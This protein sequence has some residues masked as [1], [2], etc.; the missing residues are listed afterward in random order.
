MPLAGQYARD[1][2]GGNGYLGMMDHNA[3]GTSL[4]AYGN[5]SENQWGPGGDAANII[6]HLDGF[7]HFHG[8]ATKAAVNELFDKYLRSGSVL[9][10]GS[11]YCRLWSYA[12]DRHK[13]SWTSIDHNEPLL[14]EAGK[15]GWGGR[16]VA[17]SAD[18]MP[19]AGESFDNVVGL[20]AFNTFGRMDEA[21]AEA[22]RVLKPG[23]R[24]VHIQDIPPFGDHIDKEIKELLFNVL[25]ISISSLAVAE[26]ED[27]YGRQWAFDPP[28]NADA[29]IEAYYKGKTAL[30]AGRERKMLSEVIRQRNR[31]KSPDY[32]ILFRIRM[33]YALEETGFKI[34]ECSSAGYP[35]G[36]S[37]NAIHY[38]VAEKPASQD[39]VGAKTLEVDASGDS[40]PTLR[41]RLK[42]WAT[43]ATAE[44]AAK[45]L[46]DT[47]VKGGIEPHLVWNDSQIVKTALDK[48]FELTG[49][50]LDLA[51]LGINV[52]LNGFSK[53]PAFWVR[54]GQRAGQRL[55]VNIHARLTSGARPR[56]ILHELFAINDNFP[57]ILNLALANW[58]LPPSIKRRLYGRF[59]GRFAQPTDHAGGTRGGFFSAETALFGSGLV[60]AAAGMSGRIITTA[61]LLGLIA[62]AI[63]VICVA[64][65]LRGIQPEENAEKK[66]KR[67]PGLAMGTEFGISKR[68]FDKAALIAEQMEAAD[69][70]A[71]VA[72]G[73][74]EAKIQ[75]LLRDVGDRNA[76]EFLMDRVGQLR[77]LDKPDPEKP[78][79]ISMPEAALASAKPPVARPVDVKTGTDTQLPGTAALNKSKIISGLALVG[80]ALSSINA[81]SRFTIIMNMMGVALITTSIIAWVVINFK[82]HTTTVS[83]TA[84]RKKMK[85]LIGR[86]D[87]L[88]AVMDWVAAST[89]LRF[90][91]RRER[92]QPEIKFGAAARDLEDALKDESVK[93]V[94]LMGHGQWDAW[95][96]SDGVVDEFDVGRWSQK[97][98]HKKELFI[99]YACGHRPKGESR[100]AED[101]KLGYHAVRDPIRDVRGSATLVSSSWWYDKTS[102]F[103]L[104]ELLDMKSKSIR[105]MHSLPYFLTNIIAKLFIS[106]QVGTII[107]TT[108]DLLA[109][110]NDLYRCLLTGAI[111]SLVTVIAILPVVRY[112][113]STRHMRRIVDAAKMSGKGGFAARLNEPAEELPA[114]KPAF[115]FNEKQ[116]DASADK[117]AGTRDTKHPFQLPEIRSFDEL[118]EGQVVELTRSVK[119]AK[120]R[121]K[122]S[123]LF[124]HSVN[125][126]DKTVTLHSIRH[127]RKQERTIISHFEHP[128]NIL[129]DEFRVISQP[130]GRIA[131]KLRKIWGAHTI[132]DEALEII[133]Y[134]E[135]KEEKVRFVNGNL[136]GRPRQSMPVAEALAH[137]ACREWRVEKS[138]LVLMTGG[139][140]AGPDGDEEPEADNAPGK[141]LCDYDD[142]LITGTAK[143]L[144]A[145][146]ANDSERLLVLASW[147]K[148]NVSYSIGYGGYW[149]APA[150]LTLK[151]RNGMCFNQT[152]LLVAMARSLGIRSEYGVALKKKESFR[153]ILPPDRYAKVGDYSEHVFCRFL[154]D[155][156]WKTADITYCHSAWPP[157]SDKPAATPDTG[158]I[159]YHGSLDSLARGKARKDTAAQR[160]DYEDRMAVSHIIE[161]LREDAHSRPAPKKYYTPDDETGP[162]GYPM[163]PA[164][165]AK[166]A[167]NIAAIADKETQD[168]YDAFCQAS[169]ETARVLY[170]YLKGWQ[171]GSDD[172]FVRERLLR[173]RRLD[174]SVPGVIVSLERLSE[175][176]AG[177]IS[178]K[179]EAAEPCFR[180]LSWLTPDKQAELLAWNRK[181][182]PVPGTA[183]A[184]R[185]GKRRADIAMRTS[186]SSGAIQEMDTPQ[187]MPFVGQAQG[188]LKIHRTIPR[189]R[190]Q[191]TASFPLWS[192]IFRGSGMTDKDI[193][194][195]EAPALEETGIGIK[196]YID[197]LVASKIGW[198]GWI[199][200]IP[201]IAG[202]ILSS[203]ASS[204]AAAIIAAILFPQQVP[205][206]LP[207]II[208][209][210]SVIFA[211]MHGRQTFR[212]FFMRFTAGLVFNAA[213]LLIPAAY[214]AFMPFDHLFLSCMLITPTGLSSFLLAVAAHRAWNKIWYRL[215][216][217]EYVAAMDI[218]GPAVKAPAS[219][220][221]KLLIFAAV[222]AFSA[223]TASAQTDDVNEF[224]LRRA[225]D[226]DK[227]TEL[228]VIITQ[229]CVAVGAAA[230]IIL[231]GWA[232][233]KIMLM[234]RHIDRV[235][236]TRSGI[237]EFR[238]WRS[239][240]EAQARARIL[241]VGEKEWFG[242][243]EPRP[244]PYSTLK[245]Y[246]WAAI[247]T[248]TII[249]G[250]IVLGPYVIDFIRRARSILLVMPFLALAQSPTNK[251]APRD[252]ATF[253]SWV[254]GAM[255]HFK[256]LHGSLHDLIVL[257][258]GQRQEAHQKLIAQYHATLEYM[259]GSAR[260]MGL[261]E[262]EASSIWHQ[263][264]QD[265]KLHH[266]SKINDNGIFLPIVEDWEDM[267][268]NRNIQS[269][270][271]ALEAMVIELNEYLQFK[272]FVY[273]ESH[274]RGS[275][276]A[277]RYLPDFVESKKEGVSGEI[278][279]STGKIVHETRIQ[280]A[281]GAG[282]ANVLGLGGGLIAMAALAPKTGPFTEYMRPC[283]SCAGAWFIVLGV[284]VAVLA[285]SWVLASIIGRASDNAVKDRQLLRLEN[286]N[287][288]G[289]R[290]APV[291]DPDDVRQMIKHDGR[292]E[293]EGL[294][295]T[296]NYVP[297]AR[298]E[299]F[300]IEVENGERIL[301]FI[302]VNT[303]VITGFSDTEPGHSGEGIFVDT[304]YRKRGI[305]TALVSLALGIIRDRYDEC[306]V[307]NVSDDARGF[308]EASGF[309]VTE[310][311]FIEGVRVYRMRRDLARSELPEIK[312]RLTLSER[313]KKITDGLLRR[314][315]GAA[316]MRGKGGFAAR[317]NVT[318]VPGTASEGARHHLQESG[319][320]SQGAAD[321]PKAHSTA[322][323]EAGPA[324]P[325]IHMQDSFMGRYGDIQEIIEILPKLGI[326]AP[327]ISSGRNRVVDVGVGGVPFAACE[328]AYFLKSRNPQIEIVGTELPGDAAKAHIFMDGVTL[329]AFRNYIIDA[330]VCFRR[331]CPWKPS[332]ITSVRFV[333]NDRGKVTSALVGFG[334]FGVEV[335][336]LTLDVSPD[337]AYM[338][339]GNMSQPHEHGQVFA[340]LYK[341]VEDLVEP[342]LCSGKDTTIS[343]VKIVFDPTARRL[344]TVGAD[345]VV[346]DK[347]SDD[348]R[349][350]GAAIVIA[351]FTVQHMT[352]DQKKAF[353]EETV[354][355]MLQERG[356][357]IIKNRAAKDRQGEENASAIEV[358]QKRGDKIVLVGNAFSDHKERI[359]SPDGALAEISW[360]EKKEAS[361]YLIDMIR[362]AQSRSDSLSPQ[363][364]P[365]DDLIGVGSNAARDKSL[366]GS[367]GDSQGAA[368]V[369]L[370]AGPTS[371]TTRAEKGTVP[372]S[373]AMAEKVRGLLSEAD[374]AQ[375]FGNNHRAAWKVIDAFEVLRDHPDTRWS[376]DQ[377]RT[378]LEI[379]QKYEDRWDRQIFP[380]TLAL[381]PRISMKPFLDV[382]KRAADTGE[383]DDLPKAIAAVRPK[384]VEKHDEHEM[385]LI[386]R[387]LSLG[388]LRYTPAQIRELAQDDYRRALITAND[389]F[390]HV[391]LSA[392][393]APWLQPV[394]REFF[395]KG[396]ETTQSQRG[397]PGTSDPH[398]TWMYVEGLSTENREAL[399]RGGF[400]LREAAGEWPLIG[401]RIQD[402][403]DEETIVRN[404]GRIMRLIKSQGP[405][406]VPGEDFDPP[407]ADID[408][409]TA[410]QGQPGRAANSD[411]TTPAAPSGPAAAAAEETWSV[412]EYKFSGRLRG[413][414]RISRGG[415]NV[416]RIS[417]WMEPAAIAVNACD[418]FTMTKT[419]GRR[420]YGARLLR[421][422]L[423]HA[424]DE[425]RGAGMSPKWLW[426][427]YYGA[428]PDNG[429]IKAMGDFLEKLGFKAARQSDL[430]ADPSLA[431]IVNR[432]CPP[433]EPG[434]YGGWYARIEDVSFMPK[435]PGPSGVAPY[436][437][438]GRNGPEGV[439]PKGRGP[440]PAAPAQ[441]TISTP[442][443]EEDPSRPAPDAEKQPDLPDR[444]TGLSCPVEPL[445]YAET[446][447]QL[448]VGKLERIHPARQKGELYIA[449]GTD[450]AGDIEKRGSQHHKA[451]NPFITALRNYCDDRGI[452]FFFGADSEI[453]KDVRAY[454]AENTNAK[455]LFLGATATIDR[456]ESE[457]LE[458]LLLASVDAAVAETDHIYLPEMINASLRVL[459]NGLSNEMLMSI[460]QKDYPQLGFTLDRA[461]RRIRFL[462]KTE[463]LRPEET[464]AIS[465][466]FRQFA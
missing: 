447:A 122:P 349:T 112:L 273:Y 101:D 306:L 286:E 276:L 189:H 264:A 119:G 460:I 367:E 225:A 134:A 374:E 178:D 396:I 347:I 314:I 417:L 418:D 222:T 357:C 190:A 5:A 323:G 55:A 317:L 232:A 11:G 208:A 129:N 107:Y 426:F 408:Y 215:G 230:V 341:Y 255:A 100:Y 325:A 40:E 54:A 72:T 409:A 86:Q 376:P 202:L 236:D 47:A 310:T 46:R 65:W 307:N 267:R 342:L 413:D 378:A 228:G 138:G 430:D 144:T 175:H 200:K 327:D 56:H 166:G 188:P 410:G 339:S 422:G 143:Q 260:Q 205:V 308:Y 391:F 245:S 21:V 362:S 239:A 390:R 14:D 423:A 141:S 33:R 235:S 131:N 229:G 377:V 90:Y 257:P 351:S 384:L 280:P 9:D 335:D 304:P 160:D 392:A 316:K 350:G 104:G 203:R 283:D 248:A 438:S 43:G 289:S 16:L 401:F 343:G 446:Q 345:F 243:F 120:A 26:A 167:G 234:Y 395:L 290:S 195:D 365:G 179:A 361:P 309:V 459:L 394:M 163:L 324:E 169:L 111:K 269:L 271:L 291:P 18:A 259:T 382:L 372:I 28:A 125:R 35:D 106:F 110:D 420:D 207:A 452:A 71:D 312:I 91:W 442:A 412:N 354:P 455:G 20:D 181:P 136:P 173:L 404:W 256:R 263:F 338:V 32:N 124:V 288:A 454:R 356:V 168:A 240:E 220:A 172:S 8:K 67:E 352:E 25:G 93:A 443:V 270:D 433:D 465:K 358:Y 88:G 42:K 154:V 336:A 165:Y 127:Y 13:E 435:A 68:T 192:G 153:H 150:S 298:R 463:P 458:N 22:L 457:G 17:G 411:G 399:E 466:Y 53:W 320:D 151:T 448:L 414:L 10:A 328:L 299:K 116:P 4:P 379:L 252:L 219:G 24:F 348:P 277:G 23:G 321:T 436:T 115:A 381:R 226:F 227:V 329:D 102:L 297:V 249:T 353:R 180:P 66:E 344:R 451:L 241:V 405:S 355:A 158:Q 97:A 99:T 364:H 293:I 363:F 366:Q 238:A 217:P 49:E 268:K 428:R 64:L 370:A 383:S 157:L 375:R 75:E 105:F 266:F 326:D 12:E 77:G 294:T 373:T 170:E 253:K 242:K 406:L 74:K 262:D 145:Y 60:L 337:I 31:Y 61:G 30:R 176:A 7:D 146:C 133:L 70:M 62:V 162:P 156:A 78:A 265:L 415:G 1:L 254:T 51:S 315:I 69:G 437:G 59:K 311:Y 83:G 453:E 397:G 319:S 445:S 73:G 185:E 139:I 285:V 456:L 58:P 140:A 98:G 424:I 258:I 85:I 282:G 37:G 223:I 231:I 210:N 89:V 218:E 123:I 284:T 96:A 440:Q 186:V 3:P 275:I 427:Y 302:D 148:R 197:R 118:R 247:V 274:A 87:G 212:Q 292:V 196:P 142:P 126:A 92:Y 279:I 330:F 45:E 360:R 237:S 429:R 250:I 214:F 193:A 300:S 80:I 114:A 194:L 63:G 48:Y 425:A 103:P 211:A 444:T 246:I 191:T 149:D 296:L 221:K 272:R 332:D 385:G 287:E 81:Y 403:D 15:R 159:T 27:G 450:W 322:Q 182:Q 94:A 305:G 462:P 388:V 130:R 2:E 331:Y 340:E 380:G 201:V 393:D 386:A 295:F 152:N 301:G 439:M 198:K 416:D 164:A 334:N 206:F 161:R 359:Y 79:G 449:I 371:P 216:K 34:I 434:I 121:G 303:N 389:N 233:R 407:G 52:I 209:A 44:E 204:L 36:F 461:K 400:I 431:E 147:I 41:K 199:G 261:S 421:R 278:D 108:I 128:G 318:P 177:G 6:D 39:T 184:L 19:F 464:Q 187:P 402:T 137:W 346:T 82:Y 84:P 117:S 171:E 369:P 281:P 183:P 113:T 135:Q 368:P 313:F 38:F 224:L 333:V 50:R 95:E 132:D 109:T 441:P 213:A 155:G 174:G 251:E 244:S 57:H 76:T 398:Q 29:L 432:H 419:A 387:Y